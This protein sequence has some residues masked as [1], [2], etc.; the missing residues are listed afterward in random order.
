[1]GGGGK[2]ST[3]LAYI[4]QSFHKFIVSLF[5]QSH[6]L[7]GQHFAITSESPAKYFVVEVEMFI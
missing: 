7:S 5:F 3:S 4:I 2:S 6:P 1:M